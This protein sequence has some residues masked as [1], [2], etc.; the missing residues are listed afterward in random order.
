MNGCRI[1]RVAHI[2]ATAWLNVGCLPAAGGSCMVNETEKRVCFRIS[3]EAHDRASAKASK[4]GTTINALSKLFVLRVAEQNSEEILLLNENNDR[5][6]FSLS[7]DEKEAIAH[8]AMINEWSMSKECRFRIIASLS[9]TSKLLPDEIKK[10]R[11]LRNAIDAVGRN[12]R[13]M[14]FQSKKLEV[15]DP[16]FLKE[17]ETLNN[18]MKI[19][20][21]KIDDLQESTV[22]R[23]SFNRKGIKS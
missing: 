17:I 22:D 16:T 5:L 11:G 19:A 8:Q 7:A 10:I 6:R 20:I 3:A 4:S 23:W 13:H 18:Y 12:I 21:K 15:N 2:G 9:S 14:M 1:G